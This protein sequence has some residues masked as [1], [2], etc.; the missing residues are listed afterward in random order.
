MHLFC[1]VIAMAMAIVA[2]VHQPNIAARGVGPRVVIR[3]QRG[4][5]PTREIY[6]NT[7]WHKVP[8]AAYDPESLVASLQELKAIAKDQAD[9]HLHVSTDDRE[10]L[11]VLPDLRVYNF[12]QSGF[13][14]LY[15]CAVGDVIYT[16]YGPRAITLLQWQDDPLEVY[17]LEI[18]DHHTY[19]I[20]RYE[21]LVHNMVVP[22][23]MRMQQQKNARGATQA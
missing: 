21:I 18:A 9:G 14:P 7:F 5:Q 17:E 19:F 15:Q 20:G 13:V 22:L 11:C 12:D 6:D 3:T 16:N 8:F 4:T 10:V 23:W 1:K 2:V